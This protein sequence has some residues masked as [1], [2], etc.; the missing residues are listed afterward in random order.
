M[1]EMSSYE[2]NRCVCSIGELENHPYVL[3]H[4]Y[5]FMEDYMCNAKN[6]LELLFRYKAITEDKYNE[7][8]EKIK[9]IPNDNG[10][11]RSIKAYLTNQ[12]RKIYK[13]FTS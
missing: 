1:Y 7:Y 5:M 3:T 9:K 8:L 6:S 11:T 13:E 10:M 12:K 2:A 4:R